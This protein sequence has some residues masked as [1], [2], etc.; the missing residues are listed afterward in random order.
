MKRRI[1]FVVHL[2]PPVHGVTVLNQLAIESEHIRAQFDVD[3]VPL[4]F[5]DSIDEIRSFGLRKLTRALRTGAQLAWAIARRR[6]DAVY[7]TISPTRWGF[8]RD[9]AYVAVVKAFRV[10]SVFHFHA[11]GVAERPPWVQ[12][13]VLGDAWVIHLSPRFDV[14]T[15]PAV[16][17]ERVLHVP[18]GIAAP[19]QPHNR[20]RGPA[21]IVFL[22]N[23]IEEKGPLEL[24]EA[25]AALARRGHEF[26]ATFAGARFHD[27]CVERFDALVRAHEL[28][29][30][31]R[32]VGAVYGDDKS[33]LLAEHD[34]FAFPTYHDAFPL[35]VIEAMQHGLAVVSTR[36]GAI[37]DIVVDGKTGFLIEPRDR[38]AL[39][40]R[41]ERLIVDRE[42][43][44]RMGEAGRR[45]HA[46]HFTAERFERD[47][48][49][50]LA[51]CVAYTD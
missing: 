40:D 25:L 36:E 8:Y 3:V 39:V 17:A 16:P 26:T 29:Q 42:L 11:R 20:P 32:Y 28:G 47:L 19:V 10:P 22:S 13:L 24:V 4:R 38:G 50:A 37:P 46:E 51:Q 7:F 49:Q 44:H 33:R 5:S 31:V 18:N 35:V 27:G 34:I 21:R 12:R 14:D 48:A 23:M 30:R 2:P 1:L 9:V 6:P 41:L 43:A 45:R 15:A